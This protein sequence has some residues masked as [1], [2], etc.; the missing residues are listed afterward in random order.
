MAEAIAPKL[1]GLV[2]AYLAGDP[3]AV[4]IVDV[5]VDV[6]RTVAV[7]RDLDHV[8]GPD[9]HYDEVRNDCDQACD[10]LVDAFA[11]AEAAGIVGPHVL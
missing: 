11:R 3:D 1:T 2:K 10:S 5:S 8:L 7:I 4:A 9:D 6:A